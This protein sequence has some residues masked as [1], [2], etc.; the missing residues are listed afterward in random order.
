MNTA[1]IV[2]Y[3]SLFFIPGRSHL[4]LQSFLGQGEFS[5]HV[6]EDIP[7][8]SPSCVPRGPQSFLNLLLNWLLSSTLLISCSPGWIRSRPV[9][10]LLFCLSQQFCAPPTTWAPNSSNG[11]QRWA[12]PKLQLFTSEKLL[13]V[14]CL[15]ITATVGFSGTTPLHCQQHLPPPNKLG[16]W[17]L[18]KKKQVHFFLPIFTGHKKRSESS[19]ELDSSSQIP[20]KQGAKKERSGPD[21]SVWGC[22]Q[23]GAGIHYV[24]SQ[25]TWQAWRKNAVQ[26]E[27]RNT[28]PCNH[29]RSG[30]FNCQRDCDCLGSTCSGLCIGWPFVFSSFLFF[31]S[32]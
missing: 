26:M 1:I 21:S 20:G 7:I 28:F 24:L 31:F 18:S 16:I 22:S 23:E 4:P 29:L 9:N 14:F 3:S 5:T 27:G 11:V 2:I 13:S 6:M 15:A 10:L 17:H 25:Q 32:K 30:E 8:H 12:L 19:F